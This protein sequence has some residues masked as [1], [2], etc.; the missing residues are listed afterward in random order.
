NRPISSFFDETYR[1]FGEKF[2]L[3]PGQLVVASTFEYIRIPNNLFGMLTT[4]SSWNRLGISIS[5]IVQPGYAGVL[6]LDIINHSSNPI[7]LYPGL[8][9]DQLVLFSIDDTSNQEIGYLSTPISKYKANSEP[10]L[11]SIDADDD[12][13][14]LKNKFPY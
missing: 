4:R 9:M 7:A 8:I 12:L 14:T 6:T 1:D 10:V 5:T 3:Y 11:S 2:L 13:N